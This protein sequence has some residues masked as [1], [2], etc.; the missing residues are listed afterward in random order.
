MTTTYYTLG[1]GGFV[2]ND[3]YD[4]HGDYVEVGTQLKLLN[5]SSWTTTVTEISSW[6]FGSVIIRG[7]ANQDIFTGGGSYEFEYTIGGWS[8]AGSSQCIQECDAGYKRVSNPSSTVYSVNCTPCDTGTYQDTINPTE[9]CK[10]CEAG[11]YQN[12]TGQ[13]SCINCDQGK[14]HDQTR[15]TEESSCQD[16]AAGK[17]SLAGSIRLSHCTDCDAG[18]YN[19]T[20]GS[21]CEPCPNSQYQPN[22]GSTFCS[23]CPSG[24]INYG[25]GNVL[26][27]SCVTPVDKPSGGDDGHSG[28]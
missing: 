28:K 2:V 22:T 21:P 24:K 23:S 7:D 11:K 26:L 10:E 12:N 16:C 6:I 18:K 17:S 5:G 20:Q 9:S 1:S 27:T 4:N 13:I 3:F 14:Y 25:L 8:K 15:Q 19:S